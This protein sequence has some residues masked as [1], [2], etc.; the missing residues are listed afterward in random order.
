MRH[1]LEDR[2]LQ[3]ANSSERANILQEMDK[4]AN[5][6]RHNLE[7]RLLQTANCSERANILQEMGKVV[8][9]VR[10]TKSDNHA[11][12]DAA[13]LQKPEDNNGV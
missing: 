13:K 6:V 11:R 2:L 10:H 5:R 3:T 4:L 9:Q 1:N 12:S 8:N 7:D